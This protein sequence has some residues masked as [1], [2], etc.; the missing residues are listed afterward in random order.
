[1]K[2]VSSG[3]CQKFLFS[4]VIFFELL[5]RVTVSNINLEAEHEHI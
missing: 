2:Q 3:H 5:N 1:M 4:K